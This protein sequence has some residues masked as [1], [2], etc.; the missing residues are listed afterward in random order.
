MLLGARLRIG[1]RTG[2]REARMVVAHLGRARG[3]QQVGDRLPV[4]TAVG[5]AEHELAVPVRDGIAIDGDAAESGPRSLIWRSIAAR[6]SPRRSS[7]AGDFANRPRFRTWARV[8]LHWLAHRNL[9][10][11]ES[12]NPQE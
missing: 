12:G 1:R 8:T 4:L 5:R 10:E 7:I 6:C 9:S 3:A 11:H 2:Q